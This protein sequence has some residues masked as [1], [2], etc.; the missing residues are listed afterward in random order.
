MDKRKG[1]YGVGKWDWFGIIWDIPL[2]TLT[3]PEAETA[4]GRLWWAG[5]NIGQQIIVRWP[6]GKKEFRTQNAPV[7]Q[8]SLEAGLSNGFRIS[9]EIK[10]RNWIKESVHQLSNIKSNVRDVFQLGVEFLCDFFR[11]PPKWARKDKTL[12][13]QWIEER[14]L[15][16]S[17]AVIYHYGQAL[18]N[19]E[20]FH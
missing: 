12:C 18:E 10:W 15:R 7:P 19:D 5:T 17:Y 1:G 11:A 3:S 16:K 8:T 4:R 20:N 9:Y 2:G 6:K 13:V 14:F